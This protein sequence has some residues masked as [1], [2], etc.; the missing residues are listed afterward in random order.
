MIKFTYL[1]YIIYIRMIYVNIAIK[2][3]K[4][5]STCF[6]YKDKNSVDVQK[7]DKNTIITK[8]RLFNKNKNVELVEKKRLATLRKN[9]LDQLQKTTREIAKASIKKKVFKL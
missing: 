3:L 8:T 1:D 6:T 5:S 2:H 7:S 4:N 9:K